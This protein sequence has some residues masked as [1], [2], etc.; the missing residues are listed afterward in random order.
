[1]GFGHICSLLKLDHLKR[2]ECDFQTAFRLGWHTGW[3][4]LPVSLLNHLP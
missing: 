4:F 3:V 2:S 1:M